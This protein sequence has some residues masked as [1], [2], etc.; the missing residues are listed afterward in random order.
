MRDIK[1]RAWNIK[2]KIYK[3]VGRLWFDGNSNAIGAIERSNKQDTIGVNH[4]GLGKIYDPEFVL[5]QFTGLKDKNGVEI[6][7]GD[8]IE[9]DGNKQGF[10]E[11]VFLNQ[12][13]GG[14]NL[15]YKKET[16]SLGA[17][18][19]YEL[20]VVGNIHENPELLDV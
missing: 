5:E 8:Y 20:K 11:V 9:I 6:Y 7:E 4:N 1:F 3:E 19:V 12:Y 16:M 14:W 17:R 13:V 2:R 18:K 10:F 15:K